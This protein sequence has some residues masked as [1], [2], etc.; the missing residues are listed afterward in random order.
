MDLSNG[1][2]HKSIKKRIW[3][4]TTHAGKTQRDRTIKSVD[5]NWEVI[6]S[7][8]QTGLMSLIIIAGHLLVS[9]ILAVNSI[10]KNYDDDCSG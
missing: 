5:L 8:S 1:K 7:G 10:L 4:L 3:K 9:N 2:W 6:T